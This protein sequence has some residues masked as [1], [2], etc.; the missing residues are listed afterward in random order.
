MNIYGK[1]VH[2]YIFPKV[3]DEMSI[4]ELNSARLLAKYSVER[5]FPSI[6]S[7]NR[8]CGKFKNEKELLKDVYRKSD[9]MFSICGDDLSQDF[10]IIAIDEEN[11]KRDLIFNIKP[12]LSKEAKEELYR[13]Y[14]SAI[15]RSKT[16]KR[17]NSN[18][19]WRPY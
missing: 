4:Q 10:Q 11:R 7:F 18:G 5:K 3:N 13:W 15:K 6:A 8:Y 9:F 14:N 12:K 17:E 16:L 2:M 1:A 19:L